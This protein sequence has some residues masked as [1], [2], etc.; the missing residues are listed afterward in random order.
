MISIAD[1]KLCCRIRRTQT[2]TARHLMDRQT[3]RGAFPP[4]HAV[5]GVPVTPRGHHVVLC[6]DMKDELH[7]SPPCSPSRGVPGAPDKGTGMPQRH[8]GGRRKKNMAAL[9][10]DSKHGKNGEK[11]ARYYGTAALG[12]PASSSMENIW[13]SGARRRVKYGLTNPWLRHAS[14]AA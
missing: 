9:S 6:Y 7:H 3:R 4:F 12:P 1:L 2:D 13:V 8:T 14:G 10:S 5:H 11:S